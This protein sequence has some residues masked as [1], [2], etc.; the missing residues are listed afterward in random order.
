[1]TIEQTQRPECIGVV[2]HLSRQQRN[3]V[4]LEKVR[5][6]AEVIVSKQRHGPVGTVNLQFTG[7]FTRFFN[8][9][10]DRWGEHFSLTSITIEPRTPIGE[11]TAI[12]L[13]FN[14]PERIVERRALQAIGRYPPDEAMERVD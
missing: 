13:G 9:R 14:Q 1:M 2:V 3:E 7:E 8:P 6:V 12:I 10:T 11:A 4:R 5:N